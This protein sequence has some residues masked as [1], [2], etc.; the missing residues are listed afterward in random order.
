QQQRLNA[1]RNRFDASNQRKAV[2]AGLGYTS[3]ATG[4]AM[5]RGIT[6]TLGVGY[7][8]DAMMSKTQAVTRIPDKN[9]EDMQ[10]MRHQART[11]PL[12]SKFT[13][14]EVAEGQY[15]LGRT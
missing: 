12:S 7:E 8:F 2:A 9:A 5:G 15:F 4:R 14:L 10:A 11:L 3:L 6:K 13:D 1:A